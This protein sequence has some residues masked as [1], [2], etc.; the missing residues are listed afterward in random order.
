MDNLI[1]SSRSQIPNIPKNKDI[2][3]KIE[4][5]KNEQDNTKFYRLLLHLIPRINVISNGFIDAFATRAG[6]ISILFLELLAIA[7]P[8]S[9]NGYIIC[10]LGIIFFY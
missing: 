1:I 2:Y 8:L 4:A 3:K 10:L 9:R 7:H 6:F 5:L